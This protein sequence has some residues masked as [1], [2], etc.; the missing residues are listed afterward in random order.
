MINFIY[1]RSAYSKTKKITEMIAHDH[2]NG[3]R[4]F[5]IVPEQFAVHTEREMLV[6]LPSSAQLNLEILNFSRLYNRVC[7]EYGGLEYNY[8][9]KPLKYAIMWQNLRELAPLLEVYGKYA[10]K[11]TSMCDMMISAI[12]EFKGSGITSES[13][14][15]AAKKLP[16]D[17]P[18]AQKLRDLALIYA[19]F[20]NSITRAFSD[21]SDDISKLYEV[22]TQHNF[23]ENSNV[24]ID[25]FTSFTAVEYK[26]IE[27]I[28][29]QAKN[30]TITIPL[31]CPGADTVYTKSIL[32]C[33]TKLKKSAKPCGEH[34]DIILDADTNEQARD[35]RHLANNLWST[36]CKI[37]TNDENSQAVKLLKCT[38]PYTE[39]EAAATTVLSLMREGY[40][41]RDIV[42]LAR[43]AEQ[44]RGIIE[45]AFERSDIPYYFS[46]KTDLSSTP[47]VKFLLSALRIGIYNWRTNDVISH[48]KYALYDIETRDV[49]LFEQY[50][51]TWQ[52]RGS[53]FT[54]GDFTMNPDGYTNNITERG[55]KIL[56]SAN[57]TRAFVCNALLSLFEEIESE[58][59]AVGK[60]QA[61]YRFL[62][63]S[64]VRQR[65]SALCEKEASR[66][67]TRA[68]EEY[69]KL[70]ELCCNSLA[71]L[72]EALYEDDSMC[73]DISLSE[74]HDL[75]SVYFSKTDMGAIPTSADQVVIGSASM[76]RAG[77]PKCVI[78]LG[79]CEGVFPAP[80][81]EGGILSFH[82]RALLADININ[83]SGDIGTV[84]S[85]ELM[86]V[87]RAVEMPREKL[88]VFSHMNSADGRKCSP[89]L[90]F[91][92]AAKIFPKSLEIFDS[93]DILTH[94]PTL[95]ASLQYIDSID[96]AEIAD[97]LIE[98]A[99]ED[100][101]LSLLIDKRSIPI[102]DTV[103]SVNEDTA[104]SVFGETLKLT[105][106]KIDKFVNCNFSYYCKYV[107]KLRD[108]QIMRFK[109]NDIGTFIHHVIE[110]LLAN[111]VDEN[112][113]NT[114]L[115][116][117]TIKK[118]TAEVV[119]DYIRNITPPGQAVTARLSHLYNRL[120][121]L[122][123]LLVCN[124]IEEFRH[125]SFRPEFFELDTNGEGENPAAREFE[126]SDG[127]KV[128]FSGIIDRVDILRLDDGKVYI[129]VVDYK[130]GTKQFSVED[131]KHGL[132]IQ[133]LLY[134]FTLIN[135]KNEK[136]NEL[137]GSSNP[138]A[139][140]VVY[141]SSNAPTLDLGDYEDEKNV[142]LKA[143]SNLKRS[144]LFLEDEEIL[145]A[146][147]D[148]LSPKFLGGVR[149]KADGTLSGKALASPEAFEK[150][151]DDIDRVIHRIADEMLSGNAD[152]SPL[153]YNK[154]DPCEFCEMKPICRINRQKGDN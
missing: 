46:E 37:L 67:N 45:P 99:K 64:G 106:S 50:I 81:S 2:E 7:R 12:G 60:I 29:E 91:E 65:L 129:R 140:G 92:R 62:E 55:K 24:Y 21:S 142:F 16:P 153:I 49:D 115:P 132:N 41:C 148:S 47:I 19:S 78:M 138:N 120:Y 83:L 126:L 18:L 3:V 107:L 105:Q 76:M 53:K 68:A 154:N 102:S 15:A 90:P 117:D 54:E 80:V 70:F 98:Y 69:S 9:T 109:A 85:D 130:T 38:S 128:V 121:N 48:L 27:K 124:I 75:L 32:E 87:Q 110:K 20:N 5:L 141:L 61:L 97:V 123:L 13:L 112:G 94:T 71:S 143:Q 145:R 135:N 8:V 113:I 11:D 86:Y 146:M 93:K 42:V 150:I 66:E 79:L 101:E 58:E 26:V 108:E 144:G 151:K 119:D 59:N 25:S 96:Q 28:F 77:A 95:R 63:K 1:G 89:S 31:D 82:E 88:F 139:A 134:L 84:A 103:C 6:A 17:E 131:I 56:E 116:E 22:L 72:A 114:E 52:I 35:I 125:S 118:M 149:K 36:D 34:T 43:D 127:R 111:I 136:F 33:E 14:E 73:S 133:M 4:S 39:A 57:K 51:T 147:N 152:A 10:E 74:L 40:R 137:I 23:F 100:K 30:V 44:Y 104:K 122:S